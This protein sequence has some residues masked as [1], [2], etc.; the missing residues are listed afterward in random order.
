MYYLLQ[1]TWGLLEN[2]IG[3]MVF[4]I[5]IKEPHKCEGKVI[6]TTLPYSCGSFSLGMF[7]FLEKYSSSRL[8]AHEI[9]H[10]YQNII[11]GPL[12]PFLVSIP[13]VIRFWLFGGRHLDWDAYNKAWFEGQATKLGIKHY[14]NKI[15]PAEK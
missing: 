10:S 15:R 8:V 4:F 12:K 1:L 14:L 9:G 7:V 5:F 11:F 13:S 3:F 6:Q 2:L